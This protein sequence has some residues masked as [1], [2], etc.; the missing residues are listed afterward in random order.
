M[1]KT[2]HPVKKTITKPQMAAGM[3][4]PTMRDVLRF[5]IFALLVVAPFNQGLYWPHDKLLFG[6][7]CVGLAT[8]WLLLRP[9]AGAV[10]WSLA[11][12]LG[13]LLVGLYA[14]G[15][16]RPASVNGALRGLV[17]W[18]GLLALY[19]LVSDLRF[20]ERERKELLLAVVA[21]GA[22]LALLGLAVYAGVY[23]APQHVV[24]GR[25]SAGFEYAN[26][27]ASLLLVCFLL[28]LAMGFREDR[29]AWRLFWTAAGVV[30]LPSFLLTLSRGG[31]LALVA[32]GAVLALVA[33]RKLLD[34]TAYA[35]PVMA[36]GLWATYYLVTA[37]GL[38]SFLSV[39]LLALLCAIAEA[40]VVKLYARQVG[41]V[42]AIAGVVL[43]AALVGLAFGWVDA[44]GVLPEGISGVFTRITLRG[45]LDD[46]RFVFIGDG[47]RAL[48]AS[49]WLGYGGGAWNAVYHRF[50]SFHY[51]TARAH[52]DP[53]DIVLETGGVGLLAYLAFVFLNLYRAWR[54]RAAAGNAAIGMLAF[55]VLFHSLGEA[56]LAF[57]AMYALIFAA[58][59]ALPLEGGGKSVA[60]VMR[61]GAISL[62]LALVVLAG[63]LLLAE[64]EQLRL[65]R[66]AAAGQGEEVVAALHRTLRLNPWQAEARRELDHQLSGRANQ[67]AARRVNLER[68]ASSE[69]FDPRA[70][71]LLGHWHLAQ[72]DPSRAVYYHALSLSLQPR[73]IQ[74]YE[75]LAL[76]SAAAALD[77][78][79]RGLPG[80]KRYIATVFKTYAQFKATRAAIPEHL[81]GQSAVPFAF[82]P[83]LSLA[84]GEAHALAGS[85]AAALP[86]LVA[87]L[88]NGGSALSPRAGLMRARVYEQLG[89]AAAAAA[90]VDKYGTTPE[91]IA[92]LEFLRRAVR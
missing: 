2:K 26:A 46:G 40:K 4:L 23:A 91:L 34:L 31:Y 43:A 72:G 13:A 58:C 18:A 14:V 35:V 80:A 49:P 22:A 50:Q 53:L 42:A 68:L 8:V 1:G 51:G 10:T 39:L 56:L 77:R 48:R 86:Y 30:A 15:I 12:T 3:R 45:L 67:A 32:G 16:F 75:T 90:L 11:H 84:L 69:P 7:I 73:N 78:R 25:I 47:L 36:T 74:N 54:Y 17:L 88:Q 52:S 44:P 61:Y 66:L 19:W 83:A 81:L 6:F 85:Y 64:I 87:A 60:K 76:T 29:L 20:G 21:G 70:A 27:T 41:F 62:L 9:S 92:Y 33:W 55:A 38:A 82:S 79:A 65:P 5:A 37:P 63:S 24:G 57:P 89:Q 59:G 28:S 71:N